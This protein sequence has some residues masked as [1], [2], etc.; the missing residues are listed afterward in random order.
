MYLHSTLPF[1]HTSFIPDCILKKRVKKVHVSRKL[2]GLHRFSSKSQNKTWELLAIG[3]DSISQVKYMLWKSKLK[4]L[5]RWVKIRMRNK[6]IW[7]KI[8]LNFSLVKLLATFAFMYWSTILKKIVCFIHILHTLKN[9]YL[10]I[11]Y[12]KSIT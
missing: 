5:A 7:S 6:M 1:F 8:F 9:I 2:S 12:M 10:Y 11:F 3:N 4:V